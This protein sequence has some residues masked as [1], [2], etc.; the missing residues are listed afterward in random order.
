[1]LSKEHRRSMRIAARFEE[2]GVESLVCIGVHSH[3]ELVDV[4]TM[5][6]GLHTLHSIAAG[7]PGGEAFPASVEGSDM[8][9][10]MTMR[11]S[12]TRHGKGN[13]KRFR[14]AGTG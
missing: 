12:L 7:R 3:D 10:A 13:L 14:P 8:L 4:A 11:A 6:F 9:T 2:G 1:M 5:A